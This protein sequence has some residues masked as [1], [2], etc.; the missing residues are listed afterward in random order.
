VLVIDGLFAE[1]IFTDDVGVIYR[2]GFSSPAGMI[3][4]DYYTKK[5]DRIVFEIFDVQG[6]TVVTLVDEVKSAGVY[7]VSWDV[8]SRGGGVVPAGVYFARIRNSTASS[9]EKITILK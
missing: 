9:T 1:D 3:M 5:D 2:T 7:E 4:F 8:R 6:R